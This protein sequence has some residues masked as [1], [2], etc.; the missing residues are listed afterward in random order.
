MSSVPASSAV[1]S[2]VPASGFLVPYGLGV[3]NGR[4]IVEDIR[5]AT[6]SL[7]NPSLSPEMRIN[8]VAALFM[9]NEEDKAKM[10]NDLVK[11]RERGD[12]LENRVSSLSDHLNKRVE[13]D[14]E[15]EIASL[16]FTQTAI[17]VAIKA[18][19]AVLGVSFATFAGLFVAAAG[20]VG[21]WP[22]SGLLL[23]AEFCRLIVTAPF[24]EDEYANFVKNKL[25]EYLKANPT[26]TMKE[27]S[28]WLEAEEKREKELRSSSSYE[29]PPEEPQSSGWD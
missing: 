24:K 17:K 6:T 2:S 13:Q 5:L 16:K 19:A 21:L 26:S 11:E 20:P 14:L 23:M 4:I 12:Q 22:A 10:N 15:K 7:L 28:E 27:A 29:E 9:K 18:P 3:L 25:H 1:S 8:I